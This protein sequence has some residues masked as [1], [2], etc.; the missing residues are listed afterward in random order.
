MQTASN[1][2]WLNPCNLCGSV[3]YER[4]NYRLATL[5]RCHV[6]GLVQHARQED[7]LPEE[8]LLSS[9]FFETALRRLTYQNRE[10]TPMKI[11]LIGN[12]PEE[13]LERFQD[14]RLIL[15]Q[16]SGRIGSAA[17]APEEFDMILCAQS[18]ESFPSPS[19]LFLKSRLW[20]KPEGL[21]VAGGANW[22]SLERRISTKRWLDYYPEGRYYLGFGHLRQY[23]TRFGFEIVSSGTT[24][25]LYI[26]SSVLFGSDSISVQIASIPLSIAAQL[27]RLGS[28]WWGVLVKRSLATRPLLHSPLERV[29]GVAGF[30][31]AGFQT[32]PRQVIDHN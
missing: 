28:T 9:W 15:N 7:D 18:M 22:D 19:D 10:T 31:T 30:A 5:H 4:L 24:S 11:L 32:L 13:R 25:N 20:L 1:D 14:R 3:D 23:A 26:I 12:V 16:H 6:C 21:L 8:R 29:E 17:F 27:P 2:I